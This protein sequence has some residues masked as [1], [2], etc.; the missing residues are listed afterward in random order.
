MRGLTTVRSALAS[1]GNGQLAAVSAVCFLLAVVEIAFDLVGR[2]PDPVL[3]DAL[4][5]SLGLLLVIIGTV[6]GVKAATQRSQDG[7]TSSAPPGGPEPG[8]TA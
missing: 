6:H 8:P 7:V 3:S 4:R 5:A 2:N 1:V